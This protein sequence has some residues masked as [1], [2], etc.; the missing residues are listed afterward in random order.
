MTMGLL[1]QKSSEISPSF[2]LDGS[3]V[4]YQVPINGPWVFSSA[5]EQVYFR[6]NQFLGKKGMS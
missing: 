3:R 1:E 4:V 2:W 5:I 6:P